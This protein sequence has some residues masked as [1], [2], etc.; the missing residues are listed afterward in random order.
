MIATSTSVYGLGG[1]RWMIQTE[2]S[3]FILLLC[4]HLDDIDKW[5]M[6]LRIFLVHGLCIAEVVKFFIDNAFLLLPS[7][8]YFKKY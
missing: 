4:I 3:T 2:T 8:I 6:L 7:L 5:N 1:R